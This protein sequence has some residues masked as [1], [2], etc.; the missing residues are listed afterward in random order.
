M[1]HDRRLY[2]CRHDGCEKAFLTPQARQGHE[3]V[4]ADDG[5]QTVVEGP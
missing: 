1:G 5:A 4:H 2:E 3:S